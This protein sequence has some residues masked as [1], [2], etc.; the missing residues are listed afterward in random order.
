VKE[1]PYRAW[2]SSSALA[3]VPRRLQPGG[4][5]HRIFRHADVGQ[6]ARLCRR[7]NRR[8]DRLNNHNWLLRTAIRRAQPNV[9][10]TALA[11]S[12]HHASPEPPENRE[13]ARRAVPDLTRPDVHWLASR[14]RSSARAEQSGLPSAR[15]RDCDRATAPVMPA[16][17]LT[18]Q[19]GRVC[20]L[21][22]DVGLQRVTR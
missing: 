7:Y 2:D 5:S 17:L 20:D 10:R 22:V 1:P 13:R 8:P 11:D 16:T 3:I 19:S 4:A 12:R 15:R 6:L 9:Q 14:F 18:P 21:R